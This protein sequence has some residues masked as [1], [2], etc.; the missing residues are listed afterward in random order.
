MQALKGDITTVKAIETLARIRRENRLFRYSPY[1]WQTDFHEQ[2]VNYRFRMIIAGNRVGKALRHG[3]KVATPNGFVNIELLSVGDLVIGGDGKPTKVTGVY[4][5]GLVDIYN[6]NFDGKYNI[7]TC[8]EHLWKFKK[9]NARYSTRRSHGVTEQNPFYGVWSIENTKYLSKYGSTPKNRVVVPCT[10][11]FSFEK[12]V[13]KIDPYVLG[14]L[15]GDGGFTGRGVKISSAD[16]EI[17]ESIRNFYKVNHY[18]KYDYGVLGIVKDIK[19]IGLSGKNSSEKFVPE[20]YKLSDYNDRLSII[21][22]LMDSDGY[23]SKNSGAMEYTTCS[24]ALANDF[25]W[26]CVSLGF[27]C[28]KYKRSTKAQ[29]GNGL[30]SWRILIRTGNVCPFRLSRKANLF[31]PSQETSDWILYKVEQF[32]KDYA[33]CISVD[34]NDKTYVIEHGSVTHNTYT[35]AHEIAFHATGK[36]PNDWKGIRHDTPILAWCGGITNESLRDISQKELIGGTGEAFGTG[37][38]PK[39]LLGKPNMRMAGIS[40]VVDSVKVK[41]ISGGYSE[42]VWKS[43]EQGWQKWQGTAVDYVWLDEDPNDIQLFTEAVTRLMT[44]KG[45]MLVTFTPLLGVT[46]M[47]QHFYE[48]GDKVYIKNVTWD[49]APHLTEQ[50]K[51]EMLAQYPEHERQTRSLGIPMR[52]EG[53]VFPFPE[54]KIKCEPR[55]IPKYWQ[56]IIGI[57]FGYD[58][59]A[60]TVKIAIDPDNDVV[61]VIDANKERKMDAL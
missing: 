8:A 2:G 31:R 9:P 60:A 19:T 12:K 35:A 21:Q 1:P 57:D 30:P 41:H 28:R 39:D 17:I 23:I 44:K 52:G 6:L 56:Q 24:D 37:A 50:D 16:I 43:Y 61:Y 40:G 58:H 22:G 4:N 32:G 10:K 3:T 14:L 25:E 13:T 54:D 55:E 18:S 15:L 36:Y 59:P 27:K 7:Q 53:V 46:P 33:T 48:L 45:R 42:I 29:N 38:I 11:P 49:D 34:N 26:L 5:Q 47:L 20:N 51:E